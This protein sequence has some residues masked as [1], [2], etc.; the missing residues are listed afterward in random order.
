MNNNINGNSMKIID[1][2]EEKIENPPAEK[3]ETVV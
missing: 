1:A 2:E 3:A